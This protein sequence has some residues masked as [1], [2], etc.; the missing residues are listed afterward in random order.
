MGSS[1]L[2][3]LEGRVNCL[4]LTSV[5]RVVSSGVVMGLA[6]TPGVRGS[7][8]TETGLQQRAERPSPAP[9]RKRGGPQIKCLV[10]QAVHIL[11]PQ[12]ASSV[13]H[14]GLKSEN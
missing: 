3:T 14:A 9:K 5:T 2:D 7:A 8:V 12:R 11:G 10:N 4:F 6:E 1:F 13:I